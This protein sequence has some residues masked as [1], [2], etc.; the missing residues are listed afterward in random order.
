MDNVFADIISGKTQ[1][2][3]LYEDEYVLAF[4]D[5]APEAEVHI[6]VI[7]KGQYSSYTDFVTR[8]TPDECCHFFKTISAIAMKAGLQEGFK[9]VSNSG[10]FQQIQHFHLH[11]LGKNIFK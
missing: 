10:N 1:V 7:P 11:I 2:S 6:L 5:I 9:L 3:R 4:P 8:A